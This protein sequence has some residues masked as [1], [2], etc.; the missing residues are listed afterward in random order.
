MLPHYMP[1]DNILV[2]SR[3]LHQQTNSS[4]CSPVLKKKLSKIIRVSTCNNHRYFSTAHYHYGLYSFG[5]LCL[6]HPCLA[7]IMIHVHVAV[8]NSFKN[9]RN[10]IL[11]NVVR[12][13]MSLG[14][15]MLVDI[16]YVPT[17]IY[18]GWW[19]FPMFLYT[20][21]GGYFLGQ[22]LMGLQVHHIVT[23]LM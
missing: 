9:K 19:I 21:A 6:S 16:S 10:H 22:R 18:A 15:F 17:C 13:A 5:F 1:P 4:L 20:L 12:S 11:N 8:A 23:S 7:G 2:P 3:N 14:P